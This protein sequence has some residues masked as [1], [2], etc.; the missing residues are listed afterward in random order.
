MEGCVSAA[1]IA[2][3]FSIPGS[4][5]CAVRCRAAMDSVTVIF[6]RRWP[7]SRICFYIIE[8]LFNAGVR[9]NSQSHLIPE[10]FAGG[11]V[12]FTGGARDGD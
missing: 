2:G 12:T 4:G 8:R 10:Y 6:A 5:V 9:A 11:A 3:S 1:A 7:V